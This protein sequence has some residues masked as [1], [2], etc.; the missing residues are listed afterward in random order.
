[1]ERK[2][3]TARRQG[4]QQSTQVFDETGPSSSQTPYLVPTADGVQLVSLLSVGDQVGLKADGVTPWRM[5]GIPDGIGAFDNGD[6]TITVLMNHE[7]GAANG[8]VREHGSTGAFV[9]K[10]I[11]DKSTH[12]VIHAEDLSQD[13]FLYDRTTDTYVEG[14]TQFGRLCSADLPAVSAFFDAETGLGTTER[15]FMNGEEV[16]VEGRAFAHVVTGAEAGNSYELPLLGRFSWENALANPASGAKTVVMGMDDSTPGE[17]YLYLGDKQ[18]TGSTIDKAG[19]TNGELFGIA[20][21]FGDDTGAT[22]AAGTFTL[23]AQGN[24]GDVSDTS[25]AQLQASAA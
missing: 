19:L 15:I 18:A 14:T 25:G 6:G 22:P 4:S 20:A 11:I 1:L 10:F 9:S 5:A 23:V 24:N 2:D 8:A 12:E 16:G 17:V 21:S 7:I 13:V 3:M